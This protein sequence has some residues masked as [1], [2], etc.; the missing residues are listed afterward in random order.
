MVDFMKNIVLIKANCAVGFD[1]LIAML[2]SADLYQLLEVDYTFMVFRCCR[3][4]L[5]L[6]GKKNFLK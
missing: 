4:K 1:L 5:H 6:S 2:F 3:R